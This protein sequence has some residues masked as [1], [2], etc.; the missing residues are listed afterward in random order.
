MSKRKSIEKML[1]TPESGISVKKRSLS[2]S[3]WFGKTAARGGFFA[4]ADGEG[5]GE[6]HRKCAM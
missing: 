6:L 3:G 1:W 2:G 4:R 5:R